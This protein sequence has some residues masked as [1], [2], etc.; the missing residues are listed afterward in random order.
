MLTACRPATTPAPLSPTESVAPS[1]ELTATSS[2]VPATPTS[3]ATLAPAPRFFTE[4]FNG[5]IPYWS[6]VQ[7]D[8][9]GSSVTPGTDSGFLLFNLPASNQWV[10]ALYGSKSYTAVR[11][12]AQV[13]VRTGEDGSVGIVCRYDEK[14]GW[15]EFNI[16]ADQTYTLLYGHWLADGVPQYLTMVR[17]TSEKIKPGTNEIGLSCEGHTLTPFINN[18]QMRKKPDTKYGLTDGEIGVSAASFADVP[19]SAAYDWVKVSQP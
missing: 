19:F 14:K 16:Y 1:P 18:V 8:N 7:I 15:Y 6:I 9:G 11:I 2:P 10:Y 3:T 5:E 12:D 4:D 17:A 13:E